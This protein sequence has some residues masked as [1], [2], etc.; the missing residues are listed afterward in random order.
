[1]LLA[2]IAAE[3]A[4]DPHLQALSKL[5]VASQRGE[6]TVFAHWWAS[7]FVEPMQVCSAQERASMPG[8]I[9]PSEMDVLRTTEAPSFDRHFIHLMTRHHKGAVMPN[10]ATEATRACGSCPMPSVMSSKGRSH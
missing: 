8:L 5:M 2:S 3:K 4:A 9:D 10:F 7:W 1:M 6:V